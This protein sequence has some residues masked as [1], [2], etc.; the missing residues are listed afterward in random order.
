MLCC[1][2]MVTFFG[3]L[4]PPISSVFFIYLCIHKFL[5]IIVYYCDCYFFINLCYFCIDNVK[6]NGNHFL[7]RQFKEKISCKIIVCLCVAKIYFKAIYISVTNIK[8]IWYAMFFF[9]NVKIFFTVRK[10]KNQI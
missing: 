3:A 7:A 2:I 9:K 1:I 6:N 4:S 8:V 10:I 5:L